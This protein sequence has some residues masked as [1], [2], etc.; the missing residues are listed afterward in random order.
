[1]IIVVEPAKYIDLKAQSE[2]NFLAERTSKKKKNSR[3]K[4]GDVDH[5]DPVVYKAG[6][7]DIGKK[8]I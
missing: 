4:S 8:Y 3:S 6:P 2:G 7:R 5:R 1:M